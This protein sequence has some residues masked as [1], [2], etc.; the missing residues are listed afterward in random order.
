MEE[1]MSEGW[2]IWTVGVGGAEDTEMPSQSETLHC[3]VRV[4]EGSV[5][6]GNPDGPNTGGQ[7][8]AFKTVYI[9][10]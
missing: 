1:E 6:R 9:E 5:S 4:G 2:E 8:E 3:I 10:I 7:N